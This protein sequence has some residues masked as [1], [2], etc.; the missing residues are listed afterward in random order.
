VLLSLVDRLLRLLLPKTLPTL[1]VAYAWGEADAARDGSLRN[2]MAGVIDR[3]AATGLSV[4][5]RLLYDSLELRN[6]QQ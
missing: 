5:R 3:A 2:G 4:K 6:R 1:L